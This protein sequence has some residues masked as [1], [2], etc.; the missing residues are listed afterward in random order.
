MD[1]S[2]GKDVKV[3]SLMCDHCDELVSRST[4]ERHNRKRKVELST[5]QPNI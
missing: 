1:P 2:K 5:A 4:Y 3:M